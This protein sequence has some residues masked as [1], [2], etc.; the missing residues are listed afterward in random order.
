MAPKTF[1]Y[2]YAK[3]GVLYAKVALLL[4]LVP[5]THSC[6]FGVKTK[7]NPFI[8]SDSSDLCLNLQAYNTVVY[9]SSP[10]STR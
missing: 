5:I 3:V 9:C 1:A 10:L 2:E 4:P 6:R 8:N 7:H